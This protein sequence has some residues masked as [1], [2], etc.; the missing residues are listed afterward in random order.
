MKTAV[1]TAAA[2]AAIALAAPAGA[3]GTPHGLTRHDRQV[4]RFFQHH[5]RLAA[6][7]AGGRELDRILPRLLAQIRRLQAVPAAPAHE[8]LWECISSGEG[9]QYSVGGGPTTYYYSW[10]QMTWS[11]GHG[12]V[13]D[14]RRYS[15]AQIFAA[16]EAG[17]RDSHYSTAWLEGQW[18]NTSPPCLSYA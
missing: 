14:P 15:R 3:T 9:T 7:P 6:T 18:P 12:I 16:A 11:W 1:L 13:G 10:L 17:Y 4:I 8:R 2:A 5:P